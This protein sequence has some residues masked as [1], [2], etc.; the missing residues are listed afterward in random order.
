M[1]IE[2]GIVHGAKMV[3][4]YGTAA[5]SF[6]I[7]AKLAVENIKQSGAIAMF[8]KTFIATIL[9]FM[10]FEVF[11]HHPVGVSEVHLIL[12]STLFLIFGVAPTAFGLAFGL[13]IQGLFFAPFDLP[14]YSINVTTLLMP[15]FAM[16]YVAL[17]IIPKNIAYKDIKYTDALKL[18]LMYQ[19]GIVSWVAFWALYGQ[20]FAVENLTSVVNFGIAYMSVVILEPFIDLAVLAGAKTLNSLKSSSYVEARLYNSAK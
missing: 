19:G 3:L 17:K 8:V 4:S 6:G 15:L 18:S 9:V 11:P 5:V 10:F 12:G 2:A 1:H 13:L 7:A 14:Q 16:S 20:G